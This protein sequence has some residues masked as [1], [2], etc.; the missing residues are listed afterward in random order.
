MG[1]V[2]EEEVNPYSGR[3]MHRRLD[4]KR[5]EP[6]WEEA[7]FEAAESERVPRHY[8]VPAGEK[9]ALER[10]RAHGIAVEVVE[11]AIAVPVEEIRIAS[12]ETTPKPFENHQ[13]RTVSGQ[14][15][16]A[17]RQVPAG[18]YRVTMTQPLARLALSLLEPRSND[19]LLTWNVF[20][21][22]VKRGTYPNSPFTRLNPCFE[23]PWRTIAG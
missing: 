12:T 13:E 23:P 21:E 18:T 17:E 9:T 4:V 16:P 3:V 6:M 20:E 1:E 7:T 14:Y 22:A 10:L 5:P 2:E 15:V 11:Q 19:S 8:F